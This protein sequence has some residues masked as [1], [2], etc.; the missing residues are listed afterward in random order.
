M[1]TEANKRSET[2]YLVIVGLS[3]VLGLELLRVFFP[4]VAFYLRDI[5]GVGL[6]GVIPWAVGPFVLSLAVPLLFRF[7]GRD[8]T[9][10]LSAGGLAAARLL[11][12]ISVSSAF[13]MAASFVGVTFFLWLMAGLLE[14]SGRLFT[15][16]FLA[17]LAV[18]TSVKGAATTLDLSWINETWPLILVAFAAVALGYLVYGDTALPAHQGGRTSRMAVAL[19]GFG[20]WLFLEMLILQNQGWLASATGWSAGATLLW[21]GAGNVAA[22]L[23]AARVPAR[24]GP[25]AVSGI[26]LLGVAVLSDATGVVF[27]LTALLGIA[28]GGVWLA[29]VVGEPTKASGTAGVGLGVGNVL[30]VGLALLYYLPLQLD[31]PL[32]AYQVVLVAGL[33][34]VVAAFVAVRAEEVPDVSLAP[35]FVAVATTFV[36]ALIYFL[37]VNSAQPVGEGYPVVV[38]T[39]NIA[40]GINTSGRVDPEG[41]AREIEAA[42]VEIAGLQEISRGW[43]ITGSTDFVAWMNARLRLRHSAWAWAE[44]GGNATYSLY[45]ITGTQSDL[46]PTLGTIL[47]RSYLETTISLEGELTV[48]NTHF[49]VNPREELPDAQAEAHLF[50]VHEAQF[51]VV[52]D[53]WSGRDRTVIVGDT[54]ARPHWRQTQLILDAGFEDAWEAGEGAGYTT[55]SNGVPYRIDWIFHT[56]DLTSIQAV[57][58]NTGASLDHLPVVARLR[59]AG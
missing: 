59:P 42:N 16:G 55:E 41:I 50:D 2:S 47:E 43:L 58:V 6:Y 19:A 46:L 49:Q 32:S 56:P 25:V 14:G 26:V 12:Q 51:A 8:G 33:L 44:D 5:A 30:F 21:I 54:N 22:L 15:M 35:A 13:D 9:V 10:L 57:V 38:M 4:L 52:R 48:I 28:M 24:R 29:G 31:L 34:V 45:P 27:A 1:R 37:S 7:L 3:A 23:L 18:D 40:Q 20:P 36:A 39:Y 11:E 53:A 17:G